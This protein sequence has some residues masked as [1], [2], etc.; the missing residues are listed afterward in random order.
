MRYRVRAMWSFGHSVREIERS[1]QRVLIEETSANGCV[2]LFGTFALLTF[3][4]WVMKS[5]STHSTPAQEVALAITFL[6]F[7]A[8]ALYASVRSTFKVDRASH[9]LTINR[10]IVG[11]TLASSYDA[12][13]VERL[14][15]RQTRKG[16]GLYLRLK[17]GQDKKLSWSLDF[18]P[19][20]AVAGTLNQALSILP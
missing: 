4:L 1:H 7:A 15:V 2:R 12:H 17:S 16:S 6:F 3:F 20:E 10:V 11:F 18:F 19:L 8:V 14:Y 5:R 13:A 9:Q